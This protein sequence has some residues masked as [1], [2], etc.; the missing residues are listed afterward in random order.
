MHKQKVPSLNGMVFNNQLQFNLDVPSNPNNMVSQYQHPGPIILEK[1]S[2][3]EKKLQSHE[4]TKAKSPVKLSVVSEEK[5]AWALQLARRDL[6][7]MI[8]EQRVN[9]EQTGKKNVDVI[10][11]KKKAKSSKK[12]VA[13][14]K[15]PKPMTRD[16]SQNVYKKS[17]KT[18][19]PPTKVVHFSNKGR[20]NN[21]PPGSAQK[22][23]SWQTPLQTR[24]HAAYDTKHEEN[25]PSLKER[26]SPDSHQ[27]KEIKKLR[28]ELKFYVER[29]E[30]LTEEGEPYYRLHGH[31]KYCNDVHFLEHLLFK[32]L[33]MYHLCIDGIFNFVTIIWEKSFSLNVLMFV[34]GK[35][36][37]NCLVLISFCD[38]T[39]RFCCCASLGGY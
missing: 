30:K 9:S 38:G 31:I 34:H 5:L 23:V 36:M 3:L 7:N 19:T 18:Q 27:A 2:Q 12:S 28:K 33:P 8:Q 10:T 25:H 24:E 16:T 14:T 39:H 4:K 1:F 17:V 11:K 26:L 6:K 22:L 37:D 20:L 15:R 29:I 13:V 21:M 35:L 32:S